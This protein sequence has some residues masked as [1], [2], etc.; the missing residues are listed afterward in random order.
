MQCK[1]D[2]KLH[3]QFGSKFPRRGICQIK[4]RKPGQHSPVLLP[5]R[6]DIDGTR[7]DSTDIALVK[8]VR[9]LHSSKKPLKIKR[10]PLLSFIRNPNPPILKS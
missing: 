5:A 9:R 10:Y 2:V 4:L 7:A 3:R 1:F 6:G 8:C